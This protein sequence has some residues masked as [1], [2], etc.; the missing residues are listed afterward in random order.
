MYP[1]RFMMNEHFSNTIYVWL[2]HIL[3]R[4]MQSNT[5]EEK[6]GSFSF[7]NCSGHCFYWMVV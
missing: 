3:R 4:T 2:L 5:C 1:I 7:A 6:M